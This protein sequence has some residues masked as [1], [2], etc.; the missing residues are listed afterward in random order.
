MINDIKKLY[1]EKLNGIERS[2]NLRVYFFVCAWYLAIFYS[3]GVYCELDEFNCVYC[4]L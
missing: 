1:R 2:K 3:R 4:R